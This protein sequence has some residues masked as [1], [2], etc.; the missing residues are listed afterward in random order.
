[1]CDQEL[2]RVDTM[3]TIPDY[4][5]GKVIFLTGAT[6]FIGKVLLEKLLRSCPDVAAIY[7]LIRPK[8]GLSAE[9]RK[10]KQFQE[11]VILFLRSMHFGMCVY[12]FE[13]PTFPLYQ[14]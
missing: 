4:Y 12:L 10:E 9:K 1:M 3:T 13:L 8:R 5:C 7:C 2:K 11:K 6:G 14:K